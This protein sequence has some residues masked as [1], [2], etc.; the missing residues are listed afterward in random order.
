MGVHRTPLVPFHA[1]LICR[2]REKAKSKRSQDSLSRLRFE[3]CKHSVAS[4]IVSLI[5][6]AVT[7]PE[8]S[9]KGH[10]NCSIAFLHVT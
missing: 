9:I 3:L 2:I 5:N 4:D 7:N 6:T 8:H 1:Y 10:R